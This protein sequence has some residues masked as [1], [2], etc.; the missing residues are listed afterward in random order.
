MSY[1]IRNPRTKIDCS[2]TKGRTMTNEF[3]KT[4]N[5]TAPEPRKFKNLGPPLFMI[6]DWLTDKRSR[7]LSTYDITALSRAD[8]KRDRSVPWNGEVIRSFWNF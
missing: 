7:N 3:W 4:T 1:M 6:F 8:L 5:W 2:R